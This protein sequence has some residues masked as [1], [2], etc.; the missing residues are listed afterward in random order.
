[1]KKILTNAFKEIRKQLLK[2]LSSQKKRKNAKGQITKYFDKHTEN[3]IISILKQK[4]K[5]RAIIISE[6]SKEE[7]VINEN[8]DNKPYYIIID[9]VDGSDNYT[10]GIPFVS[11]GLAV[12]DYKLEPVY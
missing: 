6:E 5:F 1:M 7:I 3:K 12:F 10:N 8:M 11:F 4:L 2:G 9:P